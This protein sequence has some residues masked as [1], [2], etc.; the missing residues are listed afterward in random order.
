[1]KS[2]APLMAEVRRQ[3]GDKPVYISFDIDG[4]D[5]AYAPGTGTPEIAGLTPAQVRGSTASFPSG[6][7]TVLLPGKEV[8]VPAQRREGLRRPGSF[9]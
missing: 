3:M 5:P 6:K 7:G 1:M 4:V 8:V 2:L 9:S